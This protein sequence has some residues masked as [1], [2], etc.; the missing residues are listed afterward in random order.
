[1]I[2]RRCSAASLVYATKNTSLWVPSSSFSSIVLP[3]PCIDPVRDRTRLRLNTFLFAPAF[4]SFVF[5]SLLSTFGRRCCAPRTSAKQ[6]SLPQHQSSPSAHSEKPFKTKCE[7]SC[8]G[9]I[10]CDPPTRQSRPRNPI[11][12]GVFLAPPICSPGIAPAVLGASFI[13]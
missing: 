12:I 9:R 5:R 2:G 3:S 7:T 11:L 6:K 4:L 13:C 8:A 10:V 1:V